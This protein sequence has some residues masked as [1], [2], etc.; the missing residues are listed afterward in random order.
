MKQMRNKCGFTY[1]LKTF[2]RRKTPSFFQ[3]AKRVYLKTEQFRLALK[4]SYD[5][6]RLRRVSRLY[7]YLV[8][9]KPASDVGADW[10]ETCYYD[11]A[12][13]VMDDAW[14]RLV[15]PF[16]KDC[17]FSSVVDLAAGHGRN[18]D[19]LK[20]MADHIH[21][22]DIN[23]SNIDFCKN[24][25]AA[26]PKFRF[27]KTNGISL[28]AIP[29]NSVTLVYSFDSMVHFDSDVIRAYLAEFR[30]VLKPGGRGFCHH[31]NY[32]GNPCGDFRKHK[33]WRN[34]MSRELF[35]HYCAKEGLVVIRSKLI[36]WVDPEVDCFT[37]FERPN[38]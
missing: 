19:K 20:E 32:I 29:S 4:K 22:V 3:G 37:L 23:Q 6:S 33:G 21:I 24:R 34:F 38:V 13:K 2:F 10:A 7:Y 1:D 14:D 15:W 9:Q 18:S 16:I 11:D 17:D 8:A 31:S 25:F 30:R 26:N 36:D 27:S 35:A 5:E 12:E 28:G